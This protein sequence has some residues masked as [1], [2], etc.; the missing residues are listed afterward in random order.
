MSET[1][2]NLLP[3][4]GHIGS[5][6][7]EPTDTSHFINKSLQKFNHHTETKFNELKKEFEEP[8]LNEEI[9]EPVMKNYSSWKWLK[10]KIDSPLAKLIPLKNYIRIHLNKILIGLTIIVL[11]LF[12]TNPSPTDF[13]RFAEFKEGP[14]IEAFK[15][16]VHKSAYKLLTDRKG[17][18]LFFSTYEYKYF[19]IGKLKKTGR[20]IGI[21]NSFYE[22]QN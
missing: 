11:I 2:F 7:I 18:Y 22:L 13:K 20:F 14:T 4:A 10:L 1:K 5:P 19:E 6:K 21:L 8:I 16:E 3:Y 15:Y 17:Y 9:V 12:I